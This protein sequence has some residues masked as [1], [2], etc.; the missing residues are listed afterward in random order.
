MGAIFIGTR[1]WG[2]TVIGLNMLSWRNM[3]HFRLG[4]HWN[5]LAGL[6]E[7][8]M[9]KSGVEGDLNCGGP[10][11]DVSEENDLS[12]WSG[13]CSYVIFTKKCVLLPL[14]KTLPEAK[15]KRFGLMALAEEISKQPTIESVLPS[16]RL[17]PQATLPAESCPTPA[18]AHTGL[19]T[20][21]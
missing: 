3:E 17:E 18:R 21:S 2:I 12:L 4:N 19:P 1:N 5:A 16:A 11:Q 8:S 14:S 6:N 20:G 7:M 9:E 15:V 10:S 13:N